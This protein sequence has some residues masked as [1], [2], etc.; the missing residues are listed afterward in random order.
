MTRSDGGENLAKTM[1]K[2]DLRSTEAGAKSSQSPPPPSSNL[3][4]ETT[5]RLSC[6]LARN[7]VAV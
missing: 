6:P 5:S 1:E 2:E 7:A 3:S 4:P